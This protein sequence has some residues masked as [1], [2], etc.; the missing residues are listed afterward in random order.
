MGWSLDIQQTSGQ[1][2]EPI[3]IGEEINFQVLLA[4][5]DRSREVTFVFKAVD[6]A[7]GDAMIATS[8]TTVFVVDPEATQLPEN[9]S[10]LFSVEIQD[11]LGEVSLTSPTPTPG[12]YLGQWTFST[13]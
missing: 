10:V 9:N 7:N 11:P 4:N 6:A 5:D 13:E 2:G 1:P 12:S 3:P 8:H